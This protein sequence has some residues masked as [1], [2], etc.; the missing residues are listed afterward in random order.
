MMPAEERGATPGAA[1]LVVEDDRQLAD[2]LRE[3]LTL[4]GHA[5]VLAGG[6]GE[7]RRCL[8]DGRF[9]LIVL[10]LNLPDGDG[11]DLAA[12]VRAEGNVP[13]LMLTARAAIDSRVAG[14]YAGANDY[15]TKPFS[16]AELLARV[17]V[18]LR[19]AGARR[20]LSYGRLTLDRETRAC[21]V[22]GRVEH[23]PEREFEVLRLLVQ[24]RGRVFTKEDLERALYGPEVPDSNT[25]EVYVYNLRRRLK[26]LGLEDVIR[27]VRNR[28]Y[29]VV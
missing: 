4:A 18:Q 26:G 21:S 17:H 25:I 29:V 13:V 23:L 20:L 22:G 15:L 5:P 9:D 24:Y 14:L 12:E 6:L 19:E 8:A 11:L 28:G 27:T 2:L 1:I 7:A 10:D 16:V 3:Q